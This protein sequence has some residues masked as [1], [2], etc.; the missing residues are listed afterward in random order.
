MPL[1]ASELPIPNP[2]IGSINSDELERGFQQ[3]NG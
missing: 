1:F 2:I 3:M